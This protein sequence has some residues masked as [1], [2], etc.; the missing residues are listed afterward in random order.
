[1]KQV[2]EN[3]RNKKMNKWNKF[4]KKKQMMKKQ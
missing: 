2:D 1:M 4:M 3:Q